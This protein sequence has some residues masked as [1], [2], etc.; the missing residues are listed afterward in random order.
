MALTD[1]LLLV[2]NIPLLCCCFAAQNLH[3]VPAV[4][5]TF[6][7]ALISTSI[8]KVTIPLFEPNTCTFRARFAYLST[9]LSLMNLRKP[10]FSGLLSLSFW[11]FG[12]LAFHPPKTSFK[13]Q[14]FFLPKDPLYL[15]MF[16]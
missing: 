7:S 15:E 1:I 5:M 4:E 3:G 14:T 13:G 16:I 12:F 8:L 2:M 11:S 9:Q 10:Y 6:A